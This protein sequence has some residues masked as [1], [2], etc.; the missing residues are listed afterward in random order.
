MTPICQF[1]GFSDTDGEHFHLHESLAFMPEKLD[2]DLRVL[3]S[4]SLTREQAA[5][6]L[7][8]AA[9]QLLQGAKQ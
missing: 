3:I 8:R 1:V 2:V 7:R 9:D 5:Q 4:T 6:M